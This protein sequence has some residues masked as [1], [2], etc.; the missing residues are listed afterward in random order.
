MI[1]AECVAAGDLEKSATRDRPAAIAVRRALLVSLCEIGNF[2]LP[3]TG[4]AA[5][6]PYRPI[7]AASVGRFALVQIDRSMT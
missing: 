1:R 6:A 4:R 5:P 2:A 3:V 7:G